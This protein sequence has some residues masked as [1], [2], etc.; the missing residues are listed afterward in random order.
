MGRKYGQNFLTNPRVLDR[1]MEVAQVQPGERIL[2]V[3][4]GKGVLTE[5]LL[6]AGAIVTAVE[7]DPELIPA[8]QQRWGGNP[9][10]RLIHEDILKTPLDPESLFGVSGTYAVI[11]NLPYYLTTPLLFRFIR[12]RE[13]F[14]RLLIMVQKEVADRLAAAT[15]DG[16]AY[17]SLS[18]AAQ[19]AFETATVMRVPPNA[20]YPPPKVDSAIVRL[21][22]RPPRIEARLEEGFL[23]Y[24]KGIFSQR[25]KLLAGTLRRAQPPWPQAA[26]D[27]ATAIV[28]DRRP[29]A[30]SP[31]EHMRVYTLLRGGTAD[32]PRAS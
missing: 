23:E 12:D 20:F 24:V 30:L 11:A 14:S 10:F 15:E 27:A 2:E 25:R 28:G 17:G 6:A 1:L 5:R 18:I 16:H 26:L 7:I 3:G 9:A 19:L 21:L 13:R 29:E 4:P 31:E 8:L 32:P 22:P